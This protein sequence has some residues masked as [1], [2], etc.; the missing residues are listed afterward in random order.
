MATQQVLTC[1]GFTTS[2]E[3]VVTCSQQAWIESYVV[4]PEIVAQIELLLAGGFSDDAFKIGLWGTLG[5]W[6]IGFGV[7]VVINI[8]R[9]AK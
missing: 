6:A 8:L 4:P 1:L 3:G 9:K 5:M 2:S 7:G